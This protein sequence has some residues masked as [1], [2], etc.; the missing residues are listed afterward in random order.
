MDYEETQY[1][2]FIIVVLSVFIV[3]IFFSYSEQW[4]THPIPKTPF[5]IME[6]LFILLLSLFYKMVVLVEEGVI[7]IIYGIGLIRIKI[8]PERIDEVK[9]F[10]VP[11]YW[12]TGIRITPKGW[13]YSLNGFKAVIIKY[14]TKEKEKTTL[15]GTPD[16]EQLKTAL[17]HHFYSIAEKNIS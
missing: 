5:L 11:W 9:V 14:R 1:G 16:P 13:L 8:K 12:G 15:I 7:R 4:G 17:E 6:G 2:W 10:K 3:S